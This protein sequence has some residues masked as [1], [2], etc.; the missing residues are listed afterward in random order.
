M[1]F[2]SQQQKKNISEVN[3]IQKVNSKIMLTD[4]LLLPLSKLYLGTC[5][6]SMVKFSAKIVRFFS[7]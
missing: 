7:Q 6:I 2:E 3:A 5:Q 1:L 4:F